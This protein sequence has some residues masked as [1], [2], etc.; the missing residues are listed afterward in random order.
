MQEVDA[1]HASKR[2]RTDTINDDGSCAVRSVEG[3]LLRWPLLAASRAG[4][5][6]DWIEDTGGEGTF[7]TVLSAEALQTLLA[8]CTHDGEE[9]TSPIA[10]LTFDKTIELLRAANF[11][12]ATDAMAA[13]SQHLWGTLLAGKS[14]EE[15][16]STLGAGDELSVEEQAAALSEPVFTPPM[17]SSV[18]PVPAAAGTSSL[19]RSLST[20]MDNDALA[21]TLQSADALMLCH[22]KAVSCAW[23]TRA[24]DELCRR[25]ACR[26]AGQPAPASLDLIV[27]LD[28]ELLQAADRMYDAVVAGQ[29]LPSLAWLR[30]WGFAVDVHAVRQ[31]DLEEGAEEEEEVEEEEELEEEKLSRVVTKLCSFTQ[32]E[33]EP[34][35]ELLL[36]AVVCA[37]SGEVLYIPVQQLREE[38]DLFELDLSQQAGVIGLRLLGLLLPA[39]KLISLE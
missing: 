32:G 13:A 24:R 26:A 29:Q 3:I 36:A 4:T 28:V 12:S 6:K 37:A 1:E 21:S 17:E 10:S 35:L 19:Q 16:R 9:A 11:L 18:P 7:G 14:V 15:L 31:A 34:P 2:S 22:L 30:G 5:L 8:A 25:A 23:R 27:D 33:G 20:R 39:C 38:G